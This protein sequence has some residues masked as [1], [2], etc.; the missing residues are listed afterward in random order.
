VQEYL[1]IDEGDTSDRPVSCL[2]FLQLPAASVLSHSPVDA[3]WLSR[4]KICKPS[5]AE[6][7][8]SRSSILL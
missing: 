4:W 5:P 1:I 8:P 3:R 6:R 7:H 2:C